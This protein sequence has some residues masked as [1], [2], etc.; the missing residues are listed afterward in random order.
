ML[1]VEDMKEVENFSGLN[2]PVDDAIDVSFE[3][4]LDPMSAE[5]APGL[6]LIMLMRIYDVQMALLAESNPERAEA[7]SRHHAE[8]KVLSAMPWIDPDSMNG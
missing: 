6:S 8:G 1:K 3:E 2:G 5:Y 4:A 7:L